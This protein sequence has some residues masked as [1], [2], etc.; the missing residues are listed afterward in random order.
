MVFQDYSGFVKVCHT[1]PAVAWFAL[2]S[3][4]RGNDDP[5]RESSRLARRNIRID[6]RHVRIDC[7]DVRRKHRNISRIGATF[8]VTVY[9][10]AR[11]TRSAST[12]REWRGDWQVLAC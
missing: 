9:A 10:L 8:A 11:V 2:D 5:A 4:F 7:R 12:L 6:R 1:L 3:R